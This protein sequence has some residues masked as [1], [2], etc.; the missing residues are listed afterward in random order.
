MALRDQSLVNYAV[1]VTLD[2]HTLVNCAVPQ[3][4][5]GKS[6]VN[7]TIP[8]AL[9]PVGSQT[10]SILAQHAEGPSSMNAFVEID[11]FIFGVD[12]GVILAPSSGVFFV[13]L[14]GAL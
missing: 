10:L 14:G 2:S 7:Y 1:T 8:V 11:K 5:G 4:H 12:A 6:L 13:Y 3:T 9:A